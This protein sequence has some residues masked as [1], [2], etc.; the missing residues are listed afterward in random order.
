MKKN[1]FTIFRIEIESDFSDLEVIVREIHEALKEIGSSSPTHREKAALGSFFHSFYNG[2]ENILKRLAEEIDNN[3]P[4]GE[5][6]H[7]AL[8]RRMELEVANV[9]PLVLRSETVEALEPYLGFRHFFRHSYTFEI[10]WQKLEALARNI[11][12]VFQAFRYDVESF[13]G[14]FMMKT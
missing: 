8:L 5:Q 1:E 14:R 10:N 2:I 11:D 12:I 6:W 13:F 4:I 3:V 7:R 9:R